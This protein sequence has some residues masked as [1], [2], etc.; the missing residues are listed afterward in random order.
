MYTTKVDTLMGSTS[1]KNFK[2]VGLQMIPLYPDLEFSR[3]YKYGKD[4]YDLKFNQ[5]S[6]EGV[7]FPKLDSEGSLHATSIRIG[8]AKVNIF[9]NRELP[10]LLFKFPDYG[11]ALPRINMGFIRFLFLREHIRF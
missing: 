4:R 6:F 9:V 10:A 11:S 2:V 5:I 8:P 3:K 7:D 1:R